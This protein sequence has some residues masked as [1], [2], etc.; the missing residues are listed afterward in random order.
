MVHFSIQIKE[1]KWVKEREGEREREGEWERVCVREREWE[2]NELNGKFSSDWLTLSNAI[3]G[4]PSQWIALPSG[5]VLYYFSGSYEWG[6]VVSDSGV[7]WRPTDIDIDPHNLIATIAHLRYCFLTVLFTFT[8]IS[9]FFHYRYYYFWI[10]GY[11]LFIWIRIF[12]YIS[13]GYGYH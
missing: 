12:R 11:K 13:I 9:N 4:L 2:R 3:T 10:F 7:W 1:R 8:F 6:L 5:L